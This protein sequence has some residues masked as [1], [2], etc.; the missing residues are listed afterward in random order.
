MVTVADTEAEGVTEVVVVRVTVRVAATERVE[1]VEGVRVTVEEML[2]ERDTV[3]V[4]LV[5][6]EEE[7]VVLVL[8]EGVSL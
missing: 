3:G 7:G 4:T 5:L 2:G 6:R 1:E 8:G